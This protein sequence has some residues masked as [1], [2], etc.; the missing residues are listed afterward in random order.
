M[1][2]DWIAIGIVAV[3]ALLGAI[4][5]FGKVL[6][7]YTSGIFGIIIS[8]FICYCIGGIILQ[9]QFVTD[10]LEKFASLWAGK[11]GFW[12]DFLTRIHVEVIVYYICLF[13]VIQIARIIIVQ[14]LKRIVEVKN[15]VMKVINRVLGAALLV[16]MT[17]LFALLVLQIIHWV[18]GSTSDALLSQLEGSV[19]KLDVVYLN[20]P[21]SALIDWIKS[22]ESILP[23]PDVPDEEGFIINMLNFV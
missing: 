21:L 1:I 5:G 8:V 19:F 13:I 2:A 15:V 11:E 3:A 18:G 16:V 10:L 4:F 14:V 20:N 12:F 22:F 7:F 23:A 9:W 17:I 6:K